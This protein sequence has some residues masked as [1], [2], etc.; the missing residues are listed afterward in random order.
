MEANIDW[1]ERES[2]RTTLQNDRLINN[3]ETAVQL[4]ERKILIS[5]ILDTLKIGL[6]SS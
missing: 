4:I 1:Y 5:W 2:F 3:L 6:P